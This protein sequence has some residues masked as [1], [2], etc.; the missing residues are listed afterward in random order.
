MFQARPGTAAREEASLLGC[1]RDS[2]VAADAR[3]DERP[4]QSRERAGSWLALALR[5]ELGLEL[6]LGGGCDWSWDWGW[7]GDRRWGQCSGPVLGAALCARYFGILRRAIPRRSRG[8]CQPAPTLISRFTRSKP[9]PKLASRFTG[10]DRRRPTDGTGRRI[11]GFC[12]P[13]GRWRPG[14]R[15]HDHDDMYGRGVIRDS[16]SIGRCNAL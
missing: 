3:L 1:F 2:D 10:R 12:P 13:A 5:L 6:G 7:L 15:R 16:E 9:A 14:S 11:R 8:A 4:A